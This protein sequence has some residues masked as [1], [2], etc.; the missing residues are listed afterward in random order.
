MPSRLPLLVTL[1]PTTQPPGACTHLGWHP[2]RVRHRVLLLL[3]ACH[4]CQP[5]SQTAAAQL[6]EAAVQGAGGVGG[7]VGLGQAR[8]A[9]QAR[10]LSRVGSMEGRVR[11]AGA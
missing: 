7:A 2:Q 6:L 3:A 8:A 9:I 10:L 5:A 4:H 11:R 1:L